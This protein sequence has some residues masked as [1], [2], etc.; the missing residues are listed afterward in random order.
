MAAGR[1]WPAKEILRGSI[2]S[3]RVEP[4]I[5]EAYG[6]LLEQIGERADAGLYLFL[7]GARTA[8]YEPAISLFQ[9][10]M[11]KRTAADLVA[12]FPATIRR[13]PFHAMA[14]AVQAE[15]RERGVTPELFGSRKGTVPRRMPG[16]ERAV[17]A[18]LLAML[19]VLA[20]ALAVGLTVSAAWLWARVK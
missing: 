11:A 8:P 12:Q 6:R 13:Q 15:L 10:R 14:P 1:L 9:R 5:V 4:D 18:A 19:A 7:S 16:R 2:A 3:G 20:V 17:F